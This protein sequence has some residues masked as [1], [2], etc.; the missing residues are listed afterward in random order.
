[1]LFNSFSFLASFAV[2]AILYYAVPGRFR[3]AMLLVGS[4]AFYATFSWPGVVQLLAVT[5]ISYVAARQMADGHRRGRVAWFVVGLG[6]TIGMLVAVKYRGFLA[7]VA[8]GPWSGGS[9]VSSSFGPDLA[10]TVGLSFYTLSCTSY[11]ADVY[12]GRMP[13]E[14]RLSRFA[15][16]VAFFPKLLAGPLERGRSFLPQLDR[17]RTF[18][19]EAVTAGLQLMLWGLFKKVVIADRLATFVAGPYA[20]PQFASPGDL[21]LATYFFAF[22]LY[23]DFSGYSDIAIGASCVLGFELAENFR[24][25][26]L[27]GS[28]REFWAA[29]WHISLASWFRDYMYVPLGGSRASVLRRDLNVLLVFV[30]SGLWHG[31]N[32]TFLCWGALNGTFHI[33]TTHLTR[34]AQRWAPRASVPKAAARV[35]GALVTFHLVL[36]SW[37]FFRSASLDDAMVVLTR[38]VRAAPSLPALV[39]MRLAQPG[40]ALSVGLI[41]VLLLV[42]ILDQLKPMWERLDA[43]PRPLRWA[44][45]YA[46]LTALFVLG[47]W[48]MHTFVYMQF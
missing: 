45:Y 2:F 31:A 23:C 28:I 12:G 48:Q 6:G 18:N 40:V 24:R 7:S 21:L 16:Y 29:R 22:Q 10:S 43:R 8:A 15:L 20:A 36:V 14:R 32:W 9:S 30:T 41:G 11:L 19:A 42:E 25:P 38:V 37:V 46:M 44:V 34:A 35:V 26:Y 1:M 3:R 5:L 27:S 47:A 33:A 17:P 39:E 13:A 4:F